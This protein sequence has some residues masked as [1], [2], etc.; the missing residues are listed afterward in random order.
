MTLALMTL[1]VVIISARA[2]IRAVPP[3]IRDAAYGV[4]ATPM[5]TAFHHVLPL[6]MPGIITGAVLG[7]VRAIGET[8]PLLLIG[9]VAFVAGTPEGPLDSAATLPALIFQWTEFSEPSFNYRAAAAILVLV[10]FLAVITALAGWCRRRFEKR[11]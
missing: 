9:M 3:S 2:S 1:P 11:W 5:Q 10:L 7:L 8:A 6:A 4:G